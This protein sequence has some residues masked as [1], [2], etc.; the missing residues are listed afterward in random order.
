[1]YF[2]QFSAAKVVPYPDAREFEKRVKAWLTV[3]EAENSYFLGHMADIGN[4]AQNHAMQLFTVEEAGQLVVAGVL[5]PNGTLCLTWAT[6]EQTE[7]IVNHAVA[8]RWRILST[9]AP[10]HVAW[11]F[12]QSYAEKTGQRAEVGRAERVYQ[13]SQHSYE[14]PSQGHLEVATPADKKFLREWVEG[15]VAE[16]GFEMEARTPDSSA[17]SAYSTKTSVSLGR[18]RSRWRWRPG[19]HQ[20]PMELQSILCTRRQSFAGRGMARR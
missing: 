6:Q 3:R 1:M 19:W 17:G 5:F 18:A 4:A 15:F 14:L 7:A 12:A 16:A 9:F 20:L 13:L 10:G 11:W 8:N 2:V